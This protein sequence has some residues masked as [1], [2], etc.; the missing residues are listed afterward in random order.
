[1]SKLEII[2]Y[3]YVRSK[4]YSNFKKLNYLDFTSFKKQLDYF[5]KNY[6]I[7]D[8]SILKENKPSLPKKSCILTFDDGYKD[9]ID[10]V[11]PEL[12]KRKLKGIFFP[13][14]I[15]TLENEILD[16]NLIQHILS[17]CKNKYHLI[18]EVE[19]LCLNNG[20][21]KKKFY[22]KYLKYSINPKKKS[23]KPTNRYDIP[24]TIFLKRL[25][26]FGLEKDLRKK[27]VR[28]LFK[29]YINIP[30]STFSKN[31]YLSKD[32]INKMLDNNMLIGSHTYN[33]VWLG[34]LSLKDQEKEI[35]V[36]LEFLNYFK[37]PTTNWIMCY[38]FGS[39]N[40]D[41]IKV[42]KKNK[43]A[44]AL[45]TK[46]KISNLNTKK[47]FELPRKDTNDYKHLY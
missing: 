36:S 8:P 25:L 41:T 13:T 33:H 46:S 27:I 19:S 21:S 11:Y 45:T 4:S 28:I 26:Q 24:N 3:H 12:K 17:V 1:M 31:F 22:K 47:I 44:S 40:S 29:K 32:D 5:Q 38:P 42:L 16:T 9:H 20:L 10:F 39:Y 34:N 15:T 6:N 37:I 7:L 2:M 14:G 30:I 43:C 18:K 35:K 23:N